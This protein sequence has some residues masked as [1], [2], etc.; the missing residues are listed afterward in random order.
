MDPGEY[1]CSAL[2][3]GRAAVSYSTGLLLQQEL[4][5]S[6]CTQGG[7]TSCMWG[8]TIR[9]TA[10]FG[11][12]LC[13]H[14]LQQQQTQDWTQLLDQLVTIAEEQLVDPWAWHTEGER[15]QVHEVQAELIEELLEDGPGHSE[16]LQPL[17]IIPGVLDNMQ[18][19]V[20]A[21]PE[22]P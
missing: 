20:L 15:D 21:G 4:G 3:S 2:P 22:G 11:Q 10:S 16:Q 18:P 19:P 17:L 6:S 12:P 1:R 9:V 14:Q 13:M 8:C 5:S 7:G